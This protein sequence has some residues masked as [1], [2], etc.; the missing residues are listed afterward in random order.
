MSLRYLTQVACISVLIAVS[1]QRNDNADTPR[2]PVDLEHS[3]ETAPQP[4]AVDH[5]S[6]QHIAIRSPEVVF[7][8]LQILLATLENWVQIGIESKLGRLCQVFRQESESVTVWRDSGTGL[9]M[10][11][12]FGPVDSPSFVCRVASLARHDERWYVKTVL[13]EDL[14]SKRTSRLEFSPERQPSLHLN[15]DNGIR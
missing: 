11:M 9:C 15:H 13:L 6:E 14:I 12:Q 3:E 5:S 10:W 7:E 4:L 8:H 2:N 1:C